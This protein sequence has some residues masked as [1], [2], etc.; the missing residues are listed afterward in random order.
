MSEGEYSGVD[1]G[2]EEDDEGGKRGRRGRRP[3]QR[4]RRRKDGDDR[5]SGKS[6]YMRSDFFK[7]EKQL[8]VYG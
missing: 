4:G 1:V 3:G 7:T 6:G 8:L 5:M 2:A